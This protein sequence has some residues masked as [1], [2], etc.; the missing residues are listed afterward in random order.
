MHVSTD[1]YWVR[2]H[3]HDTLAGETRCQLIDLDRT[4]ADRLAASLAARHHPRPVRRFAFL[5]LLRRI[6][7]P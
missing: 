6:H 1:G 5:R 7:R 4:E 2:L 3:L